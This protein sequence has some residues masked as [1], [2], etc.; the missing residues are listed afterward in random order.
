[1]YKIPILITCITILTNELVQMITF[2]CGGVEEVVHCTLL[3]YVVSEQGFSG[4]LDTVQVKFT[5]IWMRDKASDSIWV[6]LSHTIYLVW[7]RC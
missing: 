7:K 6:T 2:P 4:H 5:L 3:Y 1:M